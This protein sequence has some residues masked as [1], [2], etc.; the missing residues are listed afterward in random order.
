MPK[1][2]LTRIFRK[3]RIPILVLG[4][5]NLKQLF[6]TGFV[7]RKPYSSAPNPILRAWWLLGLGDKKK[8]SL[9]DI[10]KASDPVLHK[11]AREVGVEEIGLEWIQ[12]IVD[13][14]VWVMRKAPGVGLAAPQIGIPLRIIVL[15]D[16]KGSISYAPKEETKA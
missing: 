4:S 9:P 3:T 6:G 16:T 13:D 8:T 10:V 1:T 14:M 2:R 15:E 11:Q 12:K 7:T 5:S